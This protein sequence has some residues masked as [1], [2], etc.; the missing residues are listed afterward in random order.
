MQ[1][2]N[3]GRTMRLDITII[4]KNI[5]A[6]DTIVFGLESWLYERNFLRLPVFP[7]PCTCVR[8]LA[9]KATIS[10]AR[11]SIWIL[12]NAEVII[13]YLNF[14]HFA[15]LSSIFNRMAVNSNELF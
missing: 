6:S 15:S 4:I 11:T 12:I 5:N 1:S 10:M 8:F 3:D 9:M 2:L 14:Y 13:I 7:V